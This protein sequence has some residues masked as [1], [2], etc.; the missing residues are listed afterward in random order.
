VLRTTARH[1]I[2]LFLLSSLSQITEAQQSRQ[3]ELNFINFSS[4]NGLS[5]NTVNAIIKDRFGY[6]WFATDD[7]LNKFDGSSFTVYNHNVLDTNSIATNQ[8]QAIFEDPQGR[9]WVGTNRALSLYDRQ[10][11]CFHNYNIANGTAIRSI[12]SDGEGHLWIGSYAGLI[13][14]DP[15]S[16]HAKYYTADSARAGQLRSNTVISVFTDSRRRLWVGSN[17]GLYLYQPGVDTFRRFTN[18]SDPASISD[19]VI[20]S[21]TEDKQGHV[22]F[23]TNNGGLNRLDAD[24]SHFKNFKSSKADIHTLA[25]NRIYSVVP[26]NTG[27]LWVGTEE[28]LNIFDPQT[29]TV[30]RVTGNARNKYGFN[31]RTVRSIFIDKQG[32]YWVGTNQGGINKYDRNLGFFDL[33]QYNPFDPLGLTSP[34]ITAFAEDGVGDIY[35]GTDGGGL[36]LFHRQ[37]G[38][39]EHISLADGNNKNAGLVILALE[40][41]ENELWIGTFQHGV[42]VLDTRSKKIRHFAKGNGPQDLPNDEIFCIRKD[43][44]G[45]MW[46]GSNGKGICMYDPKLGVFRRFGPVLVDGNKNNILSNGFIRAIEED[47][48]GNIVI[49]TVGAG[50]ALYNPV[51]NI[52][53]LFNRTTV[54]LP[55]DEAISLHIDRNGTIWA[56]TPSSGLCRLD[57]RKGRFTNYSEQQGL[58]NAVIYKII[59]DDAGKLWVSTNKGISRFDPETSTFKNY[60][61]DNGLQES[62]FNLGAGLKASSGELFFGGT[63]GFNY[64]LPKALV[65]NKNIPAVVFTDLKIAGHS[66]TPAKDAAIREHISLARQIRLDYKQNFS[67]DFAA[68]DYTTPREERYMYKLDGLDRSWNE[69]GSSRTA[70]FTNL[71]PGTYTLEV[72]AKNCNG[73]WITAPATIGIFVK[74]PFWMTGYAYTAYVLMAGLILWGIRFRGIRKLKNKFALQQERLQMQQTIEQERQEAERLHEFDQLKIKFLTNLSHEFRTPISLIVGPIENLCEK[75]PD[76]D[77]QV[78]L[79]MVKRNARRLLNLVNQLLDFRKLEEQEL[80]LN[81]SEGDIIPFL[82]EAAESFR[83]IAERKRILFTFKTDVTDF[84]TS[85]D[86]DKIERMLFNLLGNAFKFTGRDGKI[87][88]EIKQEYSSNELMILVADTGIGMSAN[89]QQR[90]FD[91][92][93]QG[94]AHAGVM[95]QGNGI[96]LSITREFVRLHGG[97]IQVES[98]LGKGSVFT[99]S[100]PFQKLSGATNEMAI[101]ENI[102]GNETLSAEATQVKM[103]ALDMLTVLLVE[104]NEDFR[105]YLKCNLKPF[106]KIIEASDGREG[107]QKALSGHPDVIV[108]DIS[109]PH[110]DGIELSRKLKSDKRLSHIPII[111]L[112][113]LTEN[114]Y[115]LKGLET[116]ASDY[117]TKPFPFEI[118]KI[119]IR[120]LIL[121]NQRF[122]ETYTRRLNIET[123]VTEVESADAKL[124]LRVTQYIESNLDSANLSVEELC[125]HVYM[126]HAS[127][128]R[129]I[130][131]IT[132]ETPVEFIRSVRLNKAVDLLERSNLKIAEIG[133]AVGFTTPNYFTRAFK[134][135]FNLSPSE[136]MSLKRKQ[137]S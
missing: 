44:R 54:N 7:G 37:T 83:D 118:L 75:E 27:Q 77:K 84:Y 116:G 2:L 114:T 119:K 65:D 86:R 57:W 51:A 19:N 106:Y 135:K 47:N 107:W 35:V 131:D 99:I 55:L 137:V 111:L 8:L 14:F 4:H 30:R 97:S 49:G 126:S 42:Y 5:S 67:V 60:T 10:K 46:L 66:V 48:D 11:D 110:M 112:T 136:Y 36:N 22:W 82:R 79:S 115:Q 50:V 102:R 94:N 93:F 58:S 128:Y 109:M 95:N 56:G 69:V 74:P 92:F 73:A 15:L 41:K 127:L 87:T 63:E 25:S 62:A 20:K 52:C 38:L 90:V 68:L 89:E 64:F 53:K 98:E 43:I 16:Q 104:D 133:Y 45:N 1:T 61:S 123:A 134:G 70:V 6:M 71:Y 34:K 121:L 12:C 80:K 105:S 29:G 9:L 76:S 31:G 120:N 40:N 91:R 117:L 81:S 130:V 132:G 13:L 125:K 85:F 24:G 33:V 39:F 28:G 21:I 26:D 78:Q 32:L 101:H 113:A 72:S 129:K 59:E 88:L 122:R 103:P 18:T 108:S 96:G 3:K 17:A 100:L 23:G 124:I